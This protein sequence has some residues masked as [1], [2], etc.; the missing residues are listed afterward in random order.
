VSQSNSKDPGLNSVRKTGANNRLCSSLPVGTDQV[1][2]RFN[3]VMLAAQSAHL[4]TA[5]LQQQQLQ[6]HHYPCILDE[7]NDS[8][9]HI[10]FSL[11][12]AMT[13]SM[14]PSQQQQQ[15]DMVWGGGQNSVMKFD[16]MGA[17]DGV[18]QQHWS[19]CGGFTNDFRLNNDAY[20]NSGQ[21]AASA[22]AASA[23]SGGSPCG[24]QSSVIKT[25]SSTTPSHCSQQQHLADQSDGLIDLEVDAPTSSATPTSHPDDAS[26]ST[27]S[28]AGPYNLQ[29]RLEEIESQTAA[30]FH[31]R[32]NAS[33][34]SSLWYA[35]GFHSAE[36]DIMERA[37]TAPDEKI[38]KS[39]VLKNREV[40]ASL[41]CKELAPVRLYLH[42]NFEAAA[43][44][45]QA[46]RLVIRC[47]AFR[48][49]QLPVKECTVCSDQKHRGGWYG[50]DKRDTNSSKN[51]P[52]ALQAYWPA[53]SRSPTLHKNSLVIVRHDSVEYH[54]DSRDRVYAVLPI[55]SR[56][57]SGPIELM[58]Y[59]TCMTTHSHDATA[60]N[61]KD[62]FTSV[63]LET[64]DS[65]TDRWFSQGRCVFRMRMVTS[66]ERD[67]LNE[68][69][70]FLTP[71]Q[72]GCRMGCGHLESHNT[73]WQ[74][75][76]VLRTQ[77]QEKFDYYVQL[78]GS[79]PGVKCSKAKAKSRQ[80][81]GSNADPSDEL[82][83]L[84]GGAA[85]AVQTLPSASTD[86]LSQL[87]VLE[88]AADGSLIIRGALLSNQDSRELIASALR[89]YLAS[90]PLIRCVLRYISADA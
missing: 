66:P 40:L 49:H 57:S 69:T 53:D 47:G 31:Q 65:L 9:S 13:D 68:V 7:K 45:N 24:A 21:N 90:L 83:L 70:Q 6:H 61:S 32:L 8:V 86:S 10:D 39:I 37:L 15:Q 20:Y 29:L 72:M 38:T 85:S 3:P 27:Q 76:K 41:W 28:E 51:I 11:V 81:T 56:Q 50:A 59:Y 12:R 22:S 33:G 74:R 44:N 71:A 62:T 58:L 42:G 17:Q 60:P 77:G 67:I 5:S 55:N 79:E 78:Y 73:R 82:E 16:C 89:A 63:Q 80:A 4:S 34:G 75:A 48:Q 18:F 87:E 26:I 35:I 19:Q 88:Q 84:D 64:L 25:P 2:F 23:M 43:A 36:K 1:R 54:T 46:V 14:H 52:E 30:S